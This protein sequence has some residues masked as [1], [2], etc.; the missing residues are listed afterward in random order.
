M[1]RLGYAKDFKR[2]QNRLWHWC[3]NWLCNYEITRH[4]G[5]EFTGNKYLC[6]DIWHINLD[7]LVLIEAVKKV[8][9][10]GLEPPTR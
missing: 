10:E 7:Y 9:C 1:P 4:E 6:F 8:G 3:A 5:W 2:Q